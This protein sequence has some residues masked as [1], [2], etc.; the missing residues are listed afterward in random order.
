MSTCSRKLDMKL[1]LTWQCI[2]Y[3][4]QFEGD[5]LS[6]NWLAH[7]RLG[8]FHWFV[9]E[10]RYGLWDQ[11]RGPIHVDLSCN[12]WALQQLFST[13][14]SHYTHVKKHDFPT[15]SRYLICPVSQSAK[16]LSADFHRRAYR[17]LLRNRPCS[18]LPHVGQFPARGG[19]NMPL[20]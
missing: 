3:L 16:L 1:N 11:N 18:A 19:W 15:P 6:K 2:R 10:K 17:V 13:H 7:P 5:K 4:A 14:K 12:L 9:V 8:H 20:L